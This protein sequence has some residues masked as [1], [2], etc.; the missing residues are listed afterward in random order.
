MWNVILTANN[1]IQSTASLN[2]H[3][4]MEFKIDNTYIEEQDWYI[5]NEAKENAVDPMEYLLQR[6]RQNYNNYALVIVFTNRQF[7]NYENSI[8]WIGE[9]KQYGLCSLH[10]QHPVI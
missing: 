4:K 1:I 8:S 10:Q 7:I 9:Q 6:S 3:D 5:S 2:S